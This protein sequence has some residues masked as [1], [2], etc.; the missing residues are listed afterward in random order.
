M[1]T[2]ATLLINILPVLLLLSGC[3]TQTPTI[4]HIH[5]GHAMDGWVDTPNQAGLFVT[6]ENAAEKAVQSAEMAAA[7]QG[8][9]IRI[10]YNI[11]QVIT[12][13]N[14]EFY[15]SDAPLDKKQYGVKNALAGVAHHIIFAEESA[16]ASA[17]VRA[18]ARQ[19][20]ENSRFVLD[21]CDLI[22]ALGD[23]ALNSTSA[24]E[25]NILSQELLKLARANRDGDDSNGD[26][27][28]GS[29]PEE[30]GLKQLRTEL[31]ALIDRESPPYSTVDTWYLFNLVRLP[32]GEWIFRQLS[33]AGSSG[34]SSGY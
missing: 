16:D 33:G 21:R 4:S 25:A 29:T 32:T 23:E 5:I 17:N 15:S 7:S 24:E 28:I 31:E 14:P 11:V 10:K 13:T 8:N 6:A 9:L 3:A 20:S 27:I 1:K 18:S 12:D 2:R 19:F 22:S 26:G 30:Y 34:Q